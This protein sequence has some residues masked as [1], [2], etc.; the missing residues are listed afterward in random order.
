DPFIVFS[1]ENTP[2]GTIIDF[3]VAVTAGYYVDTIPFSLV[4]GKKAY[5]IWNPDETPA[6]GENMHTILSNLGYSGDYGTT[7]TQDLQLY[8]SVFVCVGV[9]SNNYVIGAGSPEADA[10]VDFL[11]NHGG[12]MY[13][14]GGDVWYYDPPAGYDFCPLFGINP[15]GDG[16]S[17]LGPVVGENNAFTA[18][19]NFS[20]SGENNFIDH[21]SPSGAGAFLIFHDGN[22]GYHCGVARD[23][24]AY[25][26]VGTS[27]ELGLLDDG[28]PPSTRAALLD[29]IMHFFNIS[30]GVAEQKSYSEV[31]HVMFDVF[32]N[33]CRGRINIKY[34]LDRAGGT[35][36]PVVNIKIFD[37]SGRLVRQFDHTMMGLLD[38]ISCHGVDK[39]GKE[40]A[41]G[42]YFVQFN[43]G[44][45]SK[46]QKIVFLK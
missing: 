3:Q 8:Q 18:G 43:A 27:F 44:D 21:I 30:T 20:Y 10:L 15:E 5:Y 13:L 38:H 37:V 6:P 46:T 23:Q 17:D 39:S 19:M 34:R 42:V 45:F 31:S 32:P 2:Q 33:P 40:L 25:R 12:R 35:Q 28:V 14:E 41:E 26:T 22:D 24:G 36:M 11:E 9:W 4:I 1:N 29:S 16:S 7:L